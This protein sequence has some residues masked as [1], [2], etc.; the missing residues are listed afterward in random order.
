MR[1]GREGRRLPAPIAHSL[2]ALSGAFALAA[3]TAAVPAQHD[4]LVAGFEHPPQSAR[5]RLWW[6]WM[7]GNVSAE[8]AKLDLEWMRRIGIGG[9][10]MF[11]GGKFPTPTVVNPPL[12]YMSPAWR[13]IFRRSLDQALASGMEFGIAGSPGWSETGGPWVPPVDAMKKYVW[14]ETQVEGG[15]PFTGTLA[16]PPQVTGPFQGK[17]GGASSRRAYGDAAV[18]AFPTPSLERGSPPPRWLAAGIA[19]DLSPLAPGDLS[20]GSVKLARSGREGEAWLEADYP[21]PV[22][23]GA[24]SIGVQEGADIVVQ[25]ERSSGTFESIGEGVIEGAGNPTLETAPQQTLAF[26]PVVAK[27]FRIRLRPLVVHVRGPVGLL[28]PH[29]R[30]DSF[31]LTRL[32]LLAG[33]RVNRF[34]SKAGFEPSIPENA[35]SPSAPSGAAIDP[36]KIV[37]LGARL[38]HDGTLDWT[39]PPGSWT[40]VRLG[41]SLTGRV[42]SPAEPSATGLEVDKFDPAAIRRYLS[43]YLAMYGQAS[44]GRLGRGGIQT[45]MTDSWE[46]G[47]QNW[48]PAMLADFRARRGYDP[49]PYLPV[50][51]GRVVTSAATSERFLF[52]FRQ[53]LKD[54]LADNHYGL[55]ARE[56]RARGMGYYTEAQGDSP[57]AIAD[58]MT[59]KARADIPTAEYWYRPWST[60]PGQ[61]PLKADLEEAASAGHV[62]GR[63]I[64]AAEALTVAAINDPWAFSPAMLKPVA[65][66]IFARGVNRLL[67][68]ESHLQP[69]VD[70][71]PGL[72]LFIFGQ[73]FNRND[74]WAEYARPWVD[75]LSRTSFLLQ[76]GR[77]V[78]DVAYFYGEERNLTEQFL[79]RV[80]H[81][82]PR[83]YAYDYINPEALLTL[84]SVRNGRLTTPSGMSY[85]LLLMPSQ[86]QRISVPALRRIAELVR[87]GAVLVG[88][89]PVGGLG[90][91][92]P[93]WKVKQLADQLWDTRGAGRRLGKGRVYTSLEE[94]LEREH[95]AP[96]ISFDRQADSK[97]LLTLHRRTRYA[98][99]YFISNQSDRQVA[100]EANFR[101]RDKAPELW[102]AETGSSEAL[103]YRRSRFGV[104]APLALAPHDSVFVVFR[105]RARGRE[106]SAPASR[107]TDLASI[108]GPWQVSFQPGRGAPPS[109]VFD[110]LVSWPTSSDAG[111][112]YF[113]GAATYR[114]ALTV[115]P[116][117]LA[118]ERRIALDLGEVH[119]LADIA[120]NG[121]RLGT[122]WHA[123]YEVDVTDA[124]KPGVN[125]LEI[126]VVNLWPN[127]LIG[128]R[129]AGA[130][131]IAYAPSSPYRADSPLMPS[132]LL[133]PVRVVAI[134]R[135]HGR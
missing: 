82:V 16:A 50:L 47:V 68:H 77:F 5:P 113:S 39:P 20:G 60:G 38:H 80:N 123:P 14:S 33:A 91:A 89:K 26:R 27:R 120:L 99:L 10:H 71:K 23:I 59:V 79:D 7:S 87:Q 15:R 111:I 127:R 25:A 56:L 74:T 107:R 106:W 2:A 8:G 72:S 86:V 83:G 64:V 53:T 24:V 13:D 63:P 97:D 75:Y 131:R 102:R 122:S 133:G 98:D 66:E 109:A 42:N 73:Y 58:G 32:S 114:V 126:T 62:Y 108:T 121:R 51:T 132:G 67:I 110:K 69:L 101:V 46:A 18:F 90:I 29:A 115:P 135:G 49:L 4:P 105:T 54:L 43:T 104:A 34:E 93:D 21:G 22:A 61:P 48:T 92:S 3:A 44:G 35:G 119:E 84:L 76:Q 52:D 103:S 134:D 129:Q 70:S 41:W 78:A 6:H 94:A 100:V 12:P 85:R 112:R 124:L 57:R 11:S 45:L 31:T 40:V 116:A 37:D 19:I 95:I 81:D 96:D 125:T 88:S 117:W 36:A 9:V 118:P 130:T 1:K 30:Q 128:D 28:L 65:D 17:I 55:L